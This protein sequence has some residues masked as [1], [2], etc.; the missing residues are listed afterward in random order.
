MINDAYIHHCF[1]LAEQAKG[2]TAPNPMVGAVLVHKER[3]IGEGWHHRYG[4]DHAEVNCLKNVR[5]EDKALIPESTMYVSLEPCAHY[6]ITPPCANRIVEEGIKKVVIANK[7]PF[8]KVSGSGIEILQKAGISVETGILE[9]EG[10]WLN[11]RFFCFHT[12]KRPYI[13]LKWAQTQ[14]G[15]IAKAD[16]SRQLITGEESN[17][18]VHRW[19]TEEAAIMVGTHTAVCD[20][21]QLTARLWQGKQPLRIALDRSLKIP[22]THNLYNEDAATW[23]VNDQHETLEGNVHLIQLPFNDT[24]IPSLLYRLHDAKMLSLIVEGG[25]V[26]INSFIHMGLWDEARVF[27]GKS[28]LTKGIVAPGLQNERLAFETNY[29]DDKLSVFV[30]KNSEYPYVQGMNL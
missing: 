21:P 19:R 2:L 11:R 16:R 23:I 4:S 3:V 6:G 22:H 24:L 27:T 18:V 25:T 28:K 29:G 9:H 12:K 15:F 14:D 10:L 1:E 26:L 17:K 5:E 7:D 13:I 30:N 20:D 8:E